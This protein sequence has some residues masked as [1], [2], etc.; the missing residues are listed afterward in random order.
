MLQTFGGESN[1]IPNI[2]K[3]LIGCAIFF[4]VLFC[5][6]IITTESIGLIYI[7]SGFFLVVMSVWYWSFRKVQTASKLMKDK[8]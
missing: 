5:Y 3:L 4:V 2:L 7:H 8:K 6:V 1:I